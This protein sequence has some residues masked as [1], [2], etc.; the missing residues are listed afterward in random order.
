MEHEN[1]PIYHKI[2]N[3]ADSTQLDLATGTFTLPNH[4]FNTN[5]ELTYIPQSTF[6]GIGATAVSIGTTEINSGVTTDIMPSTVYAK[7]ISE[8]KFQLFS[9]K[10]YIATGAAITFTGVGEGNAHS[11]EMGD[12]LS[13][14]V[15]GLDLSLIHI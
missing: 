8:N 14:T 1:T 5:E 15:I 4:F 7:V 3:P 2:F 6:I 12:K 10:D 13:K 11:I 9:K